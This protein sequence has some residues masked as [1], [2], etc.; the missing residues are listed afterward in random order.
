[1]YGPPPIKTLLGTD[2]NKATYTPAHFPLIQPKREHI[3]KIIIL[4]VLLEEVKV[5]RPET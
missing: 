4:H 2:T 5:F 3:L 1:M